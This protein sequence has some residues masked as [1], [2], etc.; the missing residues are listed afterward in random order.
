MGSLDLG[1]DVDRVGDLFELI[2]AVLHVPQEFFEDV[3]IHILHVRRIELVQYRL[4]GKLDD[5][6][7]VPQFV[8]KIAARAGS[9]QI[10]S[11]IRR[12][13]GHFG[14][15][16]LNLVAVLQLVSRNG[17]SIHQ[18]SVATAKVF[19]FV[20]RT[21]SMDAGVAARSLQICKSDFAGWIAPDQHVA[22]TQRIGGWGCG[23]G[24]D[25]DEHDE[26]ENPA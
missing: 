18:G 21:Q 5:Q 26:Y 19:D 12:E 17:T 9:V 20:P 14:V 22:G 10:Q 6:E 24:F 15:S 25:S 1:S 3:A 23:S 8:E 4:V 11:A 16:D 13:D 2:D 7:W